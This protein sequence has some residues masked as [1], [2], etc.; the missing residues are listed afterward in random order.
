MVALG[1]VSEATVDEVGTVS[2][3]TSCAKCNGSGVTTKYILV[4]DL[5]D[6]YLSKGAGN[7]INRIK[8]IR[9]K[10][11]LGLKSAKE[12]DEAYSRLLKELTEISYS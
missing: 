11:N 3:D 2:I 6:I 10:Y 8:E 1:V 9:A 5:A 12:V 7:K 4:K